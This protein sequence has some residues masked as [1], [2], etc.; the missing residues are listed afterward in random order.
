MRRRTEDVERVIGFAFIIIASP[1]FA[2]V[3]IAIKLEALL[4]PSARGP[5]FFVE[6]RI[7]RGKPF[8]LIKFRTLT[9]KALSEL[10]PGPSHIKHLEISGDLTKVGAWLKKWYLDELPQLIN[11]V[12][13]DMAFVG[14]RP[15]PAKMYELEIAKGI[16][17]KRDMPA[18]LVGPVQAAKGDENSPDGFK[19]DEDYFEAYKT[20]PPLK[21]LALDA[22]ITVRSL[23]VMSRHQGL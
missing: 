3:A 21:L 19:L 9:R 11:I 15:W 7:S 16:T 14:T 4:R 6:E 2:F 5:I 1:L 20:L 8:G 12:R 17:R 10:G 23:R 22:R 13:G 18:G